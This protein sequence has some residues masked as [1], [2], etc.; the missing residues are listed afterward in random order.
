ME[1][2]KVAQGG[3]LDLTMGETVVEVQKGD[4]YR[5]LGISQLFGVDLA[6]MMEGAKKE[7]ISKTCTTWSSN[8]SGRKNKAQASNMWGVAVLRYSFGTPRWM[9]TEL[10]ELTGR[11]GG[12]M[13]ACIIGEVSPESRRQRRDNFSHGLTCKGWRTHK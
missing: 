3:N 7:H 9:R 10:R 5:Y 8:I 13:E 6:K 12:R 11:Q 1:A 2:G 4:K